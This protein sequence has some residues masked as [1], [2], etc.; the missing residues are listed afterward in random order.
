MSLET[1]CFLDRSRGDFPGQ[2]AEGA[3]SSQ[4][5]WSSPWPLTSK[6]LHRAVLEFE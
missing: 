2:A 1:F 3:G 6:L 5:W 4:M